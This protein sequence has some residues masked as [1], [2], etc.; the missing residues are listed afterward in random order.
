MN[1]YRGWCDLKPGATDIAF[2]RLSVKISD[3]K[4]TLDD[5]EGVCLVIC[6]P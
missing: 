1:I 6:C 3:P 5:P 4:R 2:S